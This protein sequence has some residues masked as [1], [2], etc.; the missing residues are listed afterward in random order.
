MRIGGI[1]S[2]MDTE[3]MVKDLMKV[4]RI[5]VD[6]YLQNEQRLKWRQEAFYDVNRN[7]ANFILNTRKDLGLSQVSYTGEIQQNT[8][9]KLTWINNASSSNEAVATASAR[10]NALKGTHTLEVSQL[11]ANASVMSSADVNENLGLIGTYKINVETKTGNTT[12]ISLNLTAESSIQDVVSALNNAK[13]SVGQSLG[14]QA[15]YDSNMKRL[16]ITNKSTGA[17]NYLSI[18]AVDANSDLLMSALA[19]NYGV[20]NGKDAI[21]S[22]NGSPSM[23]NN[24]NNFSIFNIDIQLKSTN[25]GSPININVGTNVEGIAEKIKSFVTK[26]N[27]LVD[28]VSKPLN[29]EVYR[30]FM[31]LTDEQKEAMNEKDIEKW[32]EKAKSGLLRNNE[33]LSRTLQ[34]VRQS[35]YESVSIGTDD[36]IHLTEVGITTGSYQ[37]RGKL[38]I[39]ED[40]LK[41]AIVKDP[42]RVL[43]MFFKIP[44]TGL[45]GDAKFNETG[46]V[47]RLYDDLVS[48][49]KET[50]RH[51]GPGEDS[52]LFRDVQGNMLM[53][54]VTKHS[55]ISVIGKDLTS[56][57]SRIAR[58]EELLIRK[59]DRYWAR[60]TAMEKAL[61][62]M[63]EQ[64]SWLMSQLGSGQQ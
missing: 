52:T 43:D 30:D 64:S 20:T 62:K 5:R 24:N 4:E 18:S 1:A 48:G 34:K 63:N 14:I 60:F 13:D 53:D 8:I 47:Q 22:F 12:E 29:Q 36:S 54:F 32:E 25:I 45:E 26:Y 11:A 39:D 46:L 57:N 58:E 28:Q 3:Q 55:N 49:M 15:A 40:K 50:I 17:S 7:I 37:D 16:I 33:V 51:S 44:T 38:V 41:D 59:E 27:E 23:N 56:L 19:M 6:R 9:D 10:V 61:A 42:Q 31:P 21:F 35:L 2:G